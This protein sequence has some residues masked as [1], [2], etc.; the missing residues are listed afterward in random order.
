MPKRW[1]VTADNPELFAALISKTITE[2]KREK[3]KKRKGGKANWVWCRCSSF[4]PIL[5][6]SV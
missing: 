1:D 4:S 3:E 5:F 2:R 6:A